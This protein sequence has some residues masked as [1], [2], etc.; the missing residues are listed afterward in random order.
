MTDPWAAGS[1]DEVATAAADLGATATQELDAFPWVITGTADGAG[2]SLRERSGLY[3]IHLERDDGAERVLLRTGGD[4]DL[5]SP[6]AAV[7]LAV[8]TV[9]THLRQAACTHTGAPV[10]AAWCPWCGTPISDPAL[11]RDPDPAPLPDGATVHQSA[12]W[13]LGRHPHMARLIESL[14]GTVEIVDGEP[15]LD[16]EALAAALVAF[17]AWQLDTLLDQATT[18]PEAADHLAML[19]K[20]ALTQLRML[21]TLSYAGTRTGPLVSEVAEDL[22]NLGRAVAADWVRI[23]QAAIG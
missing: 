19:S 16:L 9:R 13:L 3:E 2:W 8:A 14:S 22:D 12:Q 17:E 15:E 6:T 23:I 4:V 10:E 1:A 7:R 18:K 11:P 21:A 5:P 20:S